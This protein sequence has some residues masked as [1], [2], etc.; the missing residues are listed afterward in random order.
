[1]KFMKMKI[2]HNEKIIKFT[3]LK[4]ISENG[5]T[6]TIDVAVDTLSYENSILPEVAK[7]L[8]YDTKKLGK[9]SGLF[10]FGS[11]VNQYI[12]VPELSLKGEYVLNDVKFNISD[13]YTLIE[14]G[15]EGTL[16]LNVLQ[17]FKTVI[18]YKDNILELV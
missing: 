9:N 10:G 2:K 18:D 16:G 6:T 17:N 8:G 15:I 3:E 13:D 14:S 5:M 4:I 12:Q 7:R 11:K 1:M